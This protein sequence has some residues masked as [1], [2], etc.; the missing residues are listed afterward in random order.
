M[1]IVP[2]LVEM[3][4]TAAYL[5]LLFC[6]SLIIIF[7]FCC[8]I[9]V[10]SVARVYL[11]PDGARPRPSRAIRCSRLAVRFGHPVGRNH[12]EGVGLARVS[13]LPERLLIA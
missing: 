9:V 13:I 7:V 8:L 11:S 12:G 6:C 3:T 1:L 5:G 4:L 2:T 10:V